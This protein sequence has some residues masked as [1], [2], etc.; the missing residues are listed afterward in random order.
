MIEEKKIEEVQ[1]GSYNHEKNFSGIFT[2]ITHYLSLTIT[3][4][5]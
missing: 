4:M 3:N 2:Y 1:E 5:L